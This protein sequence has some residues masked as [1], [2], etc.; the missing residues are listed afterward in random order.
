MLEIFKGENAT[1]NGCL[2][3][4]KKMAGNNPEKL[5]S[6]RGDIPKNIQSRM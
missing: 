1:C 3:H 4:S 5:G 6:C 2:A